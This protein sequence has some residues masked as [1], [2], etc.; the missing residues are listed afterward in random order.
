MARRKSNDVCKH[1][2]DKANQTAS[3]AIA[4]HALGGIIDKG[5]PYDDA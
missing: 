4:T 5:F 3:I 2:Q 1:E